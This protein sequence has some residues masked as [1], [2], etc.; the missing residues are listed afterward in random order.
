MKL[1]ALNKILPGCFSLL[2]I[3]SR[4]QEVWKIFKNNLVSGI[5]LYFEDQ[6]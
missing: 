4:R 1:L 6:T 2:V 3:L 5:Y